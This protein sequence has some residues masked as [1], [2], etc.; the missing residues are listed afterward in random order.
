MLIRQ[1]KISLTTWLPILQQTRTA[2]VVKRS[3]KPPLL[4]PDATQAEIDKSIITD[5]YRY[6]RYEVVEET[7][8]EAQNIKVILLK[9]MEDFGLRGQILT[10]N[11]VKARQDLLLP[12]LATY[13]SPENLKK[14]KDI[15][16]PEDSVSYSSEE[17]RKSLPAISKLCVPVLMNNLN[18]WTVEPWHVKV[19][20][21]KVGLNA[22]KE[23]IHLPQQPISGPNEDYEGK[24]FCV[25]LKLNEFEM[26][27]IR[28]V[29]FH[30]SA[31]D[32]LEEIPPAGWQ[33]RFNQPIFHSEKQLLES[34][35]RE[36]IEDSDVSG[37][38]DG[39]DIMQQYI[40]WRSE[41]D[42]K[43]FSS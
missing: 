23:C 11:A 2:I 32:V 21:R 3:R 4:P 9:S 10:M 33:M 25:H 5:D 43:L 18:S 17:V 31:E 40:Q 37:L 16:I 14:Y 34:L 12:K 39:A 28:C 22:D 6:M 26:V 38:A 35:P 8:T 24:E 1:A 13:A 20:L 30:W 29:L 19:A 15:V 7:D 42:K 41:R 27:P 36:K